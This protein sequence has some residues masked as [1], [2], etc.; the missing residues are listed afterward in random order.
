MRPT[1]AHITA[2]G[3]FGGLERVVSGLT[4][5]LAS[6]DADVLLVAVLEPSVP[7]PAWIAPLSA[8]GVRVEVLQV[9][10]RDYLGERRQ[11]RSLLKRHG[12]QVIHTHGYR[13]DLVHGDHARR[14]GLRTVS[15]VHG[16]TRTGGLKGRLN[17]WLQLRA[18]RR[19]DAVVAVSI[20]L[21]E[22]LT[23]VGVSTERI[24]LIPN[25]ISGASRPLDR[26]A[27]RA[28]L[29]L[30]P[31]GRAVGWVG[32]MSYE[33][34]PVAMLEAFARTRTDG[35]TL[36]F[37][38]D[39]PER[40]ECRERAQ[41]LGVA[42]RV[43]FA[44]ALPDAARFLPAF[45]VLG[46][47]SLTEGT[48]MVLLEAGLAGVPIVA[49]QVGGVPDL[50]GDGAHLVPVDDAAALANAIDAVLADPHAAAVRAAALRT[51]LETESSADAWVARHLELYQRLIARPA[52]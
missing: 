23:S 24:V 32:R 21:I 42:A 31:G 46:L 49:T 11:V 37:I 18:L 1:I 14:S 27:S 16:F 4:A 45:D 52:R 30:P 41:S 43:H 15:T 2:P 44:G 34:A 36:C 40:E 5:A 28:A 22:T 3:A 8:A 26:A 47:S 12:V 6:R 9:G 33:K 25:A 51:R 10:A 19:F 50:L 38:G 29:S 48:P 13:P 35:V 17:E 39:G 20:P 7:T